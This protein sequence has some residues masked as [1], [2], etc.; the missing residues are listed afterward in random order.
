MNLPLKARGHEDK[1]DMPLS[2]AIIIH[3]ATG[4]KIR[5]NET[6]R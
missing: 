5:G 4:V 2:E 6:S 1:L 3:S